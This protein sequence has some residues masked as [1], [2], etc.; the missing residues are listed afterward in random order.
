MHKIIEIPKL[1]DIYCP[2]LVGN[3]IIPNSGNIFSDNTFDN[4]SNKNANYCELTGLYRIWKNV[5]EDIVGICH[6]RRYF[7]QSF[8]SNNAN[9]F[10]KEKEIRKILDDYDII[11]PKIYHFKDKIISDKSTAPNI[12]DMK[13]V[14]D[15]ISELYSDYLDDYDRF[16]NQNYS[17]LFNMLVARKEVFD[18]YCDWLFNILFEVEK[19]IPSFTYKND[20][21]RIRLFGFISERLLNVWVNKNSLKIKQC[22]VVNTQ[23]NN[24]FNYKM[25]LH[26]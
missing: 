2:L 6:Y 15:V 19:R 24:I 10:L 13:Y 18:R 16:I 25:K 23:K 4:I 14:R 26:K 20:K 11:L 8:I 22:Y 9:H 1:Q 7:T 17:F 3:D 21:Y 5:K 12:E